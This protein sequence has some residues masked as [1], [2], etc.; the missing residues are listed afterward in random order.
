MKCNEKLTEDRKCQNAIYY[1]I[2]R[3]KNIPCSFNF[4]FTRNALLGSLQKFE[5]L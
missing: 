4:A 5:K 2:I 3:K 1:L